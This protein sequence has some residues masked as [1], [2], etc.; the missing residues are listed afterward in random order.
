MN[1]KIVSFRCILK[2]SFGRI[3]STS[4]AREVATSPS[5]M[6]APEGGGGMLAGLAER[7]EILK[8]GESSVVRLRADQAYGFYDP[9]KR[10]VIDRLDWPRREPPVVGQKV[11]LDDDDTPGMRVAEVT[12]QTIVLEGNH[13]LA[14]QDLVFE[15]ELLD[16]HGEVPLEELNHEPAIST[17]KVWH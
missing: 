17:E 15:I 12:S 11:V 2:D 14:G 1:A 4:Q 10:V 13:P 8:P 9:T 16:V 6:G 5:A 7:L 3:L